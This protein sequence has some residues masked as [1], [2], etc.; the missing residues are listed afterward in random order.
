VASAAISFVVL[1]LGTVRRRP[2][3]AL[4]VPSRPALDRHPVRRKLG[5]GPRSAPLSPRALD[6]DCSFS[7]ATVLVVTGLATSAVPSASVPVWIGALALLG[8]GIGIGNTGAIGLLFAAVGRGT[9]RHGDD[10]L[11]AARIVGYL[12]GPLSRRPRRTVPR[13]RRGRARYRGAVALLLGALLNATP[14]RD[15]C[16]RWRILTRTITSEREADDPGD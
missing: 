7:P 5:R 14:A 16:A 11:V 12:A 9:D 3:A 15:R 10:R 4:R 8:I 2:T 1:A 13:L 6:R